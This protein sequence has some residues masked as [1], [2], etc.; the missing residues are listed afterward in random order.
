MA[1]LLALLSALLFG[2]MT[3]AI[4]F[5]FSRGTDPLLAS[6][7]MSLV[8][9]T[10]CGVV[11]AIV[12]QGGNAGV[13]AL[14]PF[15]VAGLIAPGLSQLLFARAIKEAGASRASVVVGTAPL[16]SVA[17]ALAILRE[18]AKAA[19]LVGAGLIVAG[20]VALAGEPGR[21]DAF[22]AYGLLLAAGATVLFAARDNLIRWLAG[23]GHAAP[24]PAATTTLLAGSIAM[25]ALAARGFRPGGARRFTVA[26]RAFLP[27]GILFGVSYVALFEAY[28]RGR[29]TVV[30]PLVATESLWGVTLSA[31]LLQRS[32]LVGRR[33]FLGA[34][35]VVA[36]GVLIG[37][38]SS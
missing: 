31:L 2:A 18:P 13:D 6:F 15:A 4:R 3:V 21:P 10:I 29:V 27:A 20:G 1:V 38:A 25:G 28:H 8:A 33:I 12:P 34:A 7:A 36:G 35:L 22:R 5:G 19:L 32:E 26:L 9:L 16:I 30:S 14:W 24:L 11:T 37:T 17:I 23:E